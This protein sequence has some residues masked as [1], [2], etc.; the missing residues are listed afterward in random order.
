M[1]SKSEKSLPIPEFITDVIEETDEERF[2][3]TRTPS[4]LVIL[5]HGIRSRGGWYEQVIDFLENSKFKVRNISCGRIGSV[6]FLF[7]LA[8]GVEKYYVNRL[9]RQIVAAM[10]KEGSGACSIICHSFGTYLLS[11]VIEA[12]QDLVFD[13]IILCGS[14]IPQEFEWERYSNQFNEIINECGQNDTVVRLAPILS[15]KLGSTGRFGFR[16]PLIQDRFHHNTGHGDFF[17]RSFD[18]GLWARFIREGEYVRTGIQMREDTGLETLALT[19]IKLVAWPFKLLFRIT[20][21]PSNL[22]SYFMKS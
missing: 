5:L 22:I 8:F 19:L 14:V 9:H 6:E 13:R 2:W 1:S 12:N 18:L 10:S 20:N 11:K 15:H 7:F 16:N 21:I 3:E 4:E 17:S